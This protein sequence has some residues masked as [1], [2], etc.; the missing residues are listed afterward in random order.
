MGIAHASWLNFRNTEYAPGFVCKMVNTYC[1]VVEDELDLNLTIVDSDNSHL[2]WEVSLFSGN[3]S[4]M[5]PLGKAPT[6]DILRKAFFNAYVLLARLGEER[7][8]V[9]VPDEEFGV[10]YGCLTTRSN[11]GYAL[12]LW[13]F[14]DGL[15]GEVN[16][17]KIALSLTGL[18]EK[19]CYKVVTYRID[20][21]HA[22]AYGTWMSMGRPYPLTKEQII[23]LRGND[24]LTPDPLIPQ[25]KGD[26]YTRF[27]ELPMHSVV[28]LL[29]IKDEERWT[30][31]LVIKTPI[32]EK[33]VLGDNQ[34]FLSW[35]YAKRPDFVGYEVLR[36]G[37][38]LNSHLIA[39]ACFVDCDVE[40]GKRYMYAIRAVY[41]N[42]TSETKPVEVL[43]G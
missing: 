5:T 31:S 22:N 21:S 18:G 41:T 8:I 6:T 2:P 4:Q 42:G 28:L 37:Q 12:M 11:A 40:K 23:T 39:D 16:A 19:D 29:L 9:D 30:E 33:S 38:V 14:E 17:R 25:T 13:N 43:I 27:F 20:R 15:D 10:K 34:V 26:R 35:S 24:F 7:L 36:D 3:R 32:V 1:D